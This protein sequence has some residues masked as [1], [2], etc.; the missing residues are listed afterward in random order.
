MTIPSCVVVLN[1]DPRSESSQ[2]DYLLARD[3]TEGGTVSA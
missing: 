3:L 2:M 1:Q